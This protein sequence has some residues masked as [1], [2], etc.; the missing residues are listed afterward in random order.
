LL[1]FY[2]QGAHILTASWVQHN[3]LQ[4]WDYRKGCLVQNLPF[5]VKPE[6]TDGGIVTGAGDSGE[7]VGNGAYLYCGQFCTNDVVI[8]GGSG[9]KSVQA[10]SRQTG[11]VGYYNL[12][13][14]SN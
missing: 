6:A 7:Q 12:N 9:T 10:I 13:E 5:C 1:T 4:L 3:A 14:N 8:A 11:Q 2:F